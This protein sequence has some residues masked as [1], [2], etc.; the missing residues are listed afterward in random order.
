MD[1]LNDELGSSNELCV[2]STLDGN[3]VIGIE[4]E[5][6]SGVS[7]VADQE[8]TTIPPIPHAATIQAPCHDVLSGPKVK[9]SHPV[10]WNDVLI[11]VFNE[12]KPS[13]S[14]AAVL[15]HPHPTAPLALVT[16][17]ST[18]AMGAVLQQQVQDVWQP[19]ASFSR[20][21]SLAQQKYSAYCARQG[22]PGDL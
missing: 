13:L 10:T 14:Q 15:A 8:T 2:T 11:A 5:G 21:V 1:L 4:V 3:E 17:A 6:L 19:L 18:T 22:A 16:D 20:K 7:E 9:G 12:C